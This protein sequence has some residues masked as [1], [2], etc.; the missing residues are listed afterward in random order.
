MVL[1][2]D[3]GAPVLRAVSQLRNTY[4]RIPVIAR[5]RDLKASAHLLKAGAT[6]AFPETIEASLRLGAEA[7]KMV[8][9]PED[10]VQLWM[11]GIRSS[12]YQRVQEAGGNTAATRQK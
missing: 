10:K 11:E 2:I 9:S 8:G 7:L 4:P 6:Q 3:H 1:T 12:G 5:A